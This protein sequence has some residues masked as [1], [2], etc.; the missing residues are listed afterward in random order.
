MSEELLAV[1]PF[2]PPVYQNPGGKPPTS[3]PPPGQ[4]SVTQ[5]QNVVT[6]RYEVFRDGYR[7]A[8]AKTS[9]HASE[10]AAHATNSWPNPYQAP[11]VTSFEPP[12]G[13]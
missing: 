10:L 7:I 5:A 2:K 3:I 13:S 12:A 4:T 8:V 1:T 11:I 6:G 9:F